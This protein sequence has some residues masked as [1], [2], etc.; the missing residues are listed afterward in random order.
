[1]HENLV[2][3]FFEEPKLFLPED[4]VDEKLHAEYIDKIF[5][6]DADAVESNLENSYQAFSKINID[7][8]NETQPW[9][10]IGA[11][12]LQTPYS[13]VY[14]ALNL[15]ANKKIKYVVDIGAAYGRVGIVTR[16]L[17]PEA[18]F[19]G[20]EVM[21]ERVAEG[22]RVF[23]KNKINHCDLFAKNVLD[24]NFELPEA[25]VYF[26][27]DFSEPE[28]LQVIFDQIINRAT[29][30]DRE[31]FL[32]IRGPGGEKLM[33]TRYQNQMLLMGE[34]QNRLL[35]VFACRAFV[36]TD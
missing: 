16:A 1:M 35:K 8:A 15:F 28:H 6:F 25:D 7:D 31:F 3:Q 2:K 24:Q 33:E 19:V 26:I 29:S 32:I 34:S 20:Y 13:A 12:T 22:N 5:G 11:Q 36:S 23:Q 17:F 21:A 10:G 27:Y 4:G 18:K 30:G 14:R 9:I